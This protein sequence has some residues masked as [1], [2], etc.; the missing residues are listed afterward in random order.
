MILKSAF[1]EPAINV[2]PLHTFPVRP[3][4]AAADATDSEPHESL[5]T[6]VNRVCD[7][8]IADAPSSRRME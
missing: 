8:Y 3:L 4:A 6:V 2:S 5:W 1:A 7:R